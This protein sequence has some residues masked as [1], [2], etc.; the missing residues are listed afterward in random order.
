MSFNQ[1]KLSESFNQSRGIFNKYIYESD[2]QL[3]KI[4]SPDYFAESRFLISEP[5]KWKGALIDVSSIDSY[6]VLK[7]T[8]DGLSAEQ[9]GVGNNTVITVTGTSKTLSLQDR[10]TFQ[11]LSNASAQTLIIPPDVDVPFK[12]DDEI[13]I[14]QSGFGVVSIAA[15]AG[16]TILSEGGMLSI[17]NQF[18]AVTIK[19]ILINTWTLIGALS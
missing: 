4:I 19:K 15:D 2:D 11:V 14:F 12:I 9:S 1:F 3:V 17:S 10:N 6:V 5:D 7:V 18:T 16:V 13:D 8:D